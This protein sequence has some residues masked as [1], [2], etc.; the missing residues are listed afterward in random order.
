M[1]SLFGCLC[2]FFAQACFSQ[3]KINSV[4]VLQLGK[5]DTEIINALNILPRDIVNGNPQSNSELLY[6]LKNSVVCLR[7]STDNIQ[8]DTGYVHTAF[9]GD[10]VKRK[11][12][13][14]SPDVIFYF[15]PDFHFNGADLGH[16]ALVFYQHQLAAI[17]SEWADD[18]PYY[19]FEDVFEKAYP[20]FKHN[21]SDYSTDDGLTFRE[22]DDWNSNVPGVEVSCLRGGFQADKKG[23][24]SY[25]YR[26]FS[27]ENKTIMKKVGDLLE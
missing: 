11:W 2:I 8:P 21:S 24:D 25:Y 15:L 22:G 9:R 26:V 7:R 16:V 17:Y 1:K 10:A 3:Q 19:S 14:S 6:S 5:S 18:N 23:E 13:G 12:F 27:I 4:G 20:D